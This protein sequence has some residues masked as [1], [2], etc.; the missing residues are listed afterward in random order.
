M[1][2]YGP[3][4]YDVV[5]FMSYAGGSSLQAS[6]QPLTREESQTIRVVDMHKGRTPHQ[7]FRDAREGSGLKGEPQLV[8]RNPMGTTTAQENGGQAIQEMPLMTDVPVMK[9]AGDISAAREQGSRAMSTNGFTY[10]GQKI[11]LR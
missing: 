1:R 5:W 2:Y 8:F 4:G 10:I 7:V 9:W 6:L 3:E 11:C